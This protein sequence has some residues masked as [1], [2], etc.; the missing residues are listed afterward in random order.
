MLA[1][2]LKIDSPH[3]RRGNV[4]GYSLPELF[5]VL[6]LLSIMAAQAA[7]AFQQIIGT[8]TKL[9]DKNTDRFTQIFST[10]AELI[11]QGFINASKIDL[12]ATKW[13]NPENNKVG[14]V[15]H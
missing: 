2:T 7:P 12:Y 14:L 4:P 11:K 6:A 1:L 5:V 3:S 13:F 15:Y 8:K 10:E 9:I